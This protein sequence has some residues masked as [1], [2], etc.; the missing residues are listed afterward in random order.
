MVADSTYSRFTGRVILCLSTNRSKPES[1]E[2]AVFGYKS[3]LIKTLLGLTSWLKFANSL[4]IKIFILTMS[5]SAGE[6]ATF[7]RQILVSLLQVYMMPVANYSK[8]EVDFLSFSCYAQADASSWSGHGGS[9][10]N[11]S[12]TRINSKPQGHVRSLPRSV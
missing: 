3:I 10:W 11:W 9:P 8:M 4:Y 2:S 7:T 6:E 1:S 12:S 5:S